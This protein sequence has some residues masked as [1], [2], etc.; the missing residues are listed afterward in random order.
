MKAWLLYTCLGYQGLQETLTGDAEQNVCSLLLVQV[1]NGDI[2][3]GCQLWLGFQEEIRLRPSESAN[4]SQLVVGTPPG[5][6]PPLNESRNPIASPKYKLA[7]SANACIL[8]P[9]LLFLCLG[10]FHDEPLVTAG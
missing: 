1:N 9:P 10:G 2:T 4:F 8:P 5:C 3:V 6:R 7:H